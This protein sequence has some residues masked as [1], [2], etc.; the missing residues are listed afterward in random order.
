LE[1]KV[2]KIVKVLPKLNCGKCGFDNCGKFARAVAKEKASCY[3]CVSGG[4]L[5]ANKV[6]E[7]MGVRVPE[8]TKISASYPG[9]PQP[10]VASGRMN[11]GRSKS[12]GWSRNRGKD[13]GFGRRMRRGRAPSKISPPDNLRKKL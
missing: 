1:E 11:R 5:V 4:P 12:L 8:K 10:R 13:K 7:I 6:C 2:K 9:S 3:G